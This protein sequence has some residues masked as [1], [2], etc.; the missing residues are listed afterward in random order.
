MSDNLPN[1]LV[2]CGALFAALMDS[3]VTVE[4]IIEDEDTAAMVVRFDFLRSPYRV[5]VTME[6]TGP[7]REPE[8][9]AS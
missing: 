4:R 2:A 7:T 8:E 6:P 9:A 3:P 5:T 1:E